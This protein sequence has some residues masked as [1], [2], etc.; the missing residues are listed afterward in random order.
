[1]DEGGTGTGATRGGILLILNCSVFRGRLI[2]FCRVSISKSVCSI[3]AE[4]EFNGGSVS[5]EQVN[6]GGLNEVLQLLFT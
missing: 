1:M 6:R 3:G 2:N 4:N 5:R